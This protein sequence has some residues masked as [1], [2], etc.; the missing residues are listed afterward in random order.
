MIKD[1]ENLLVTGQIPE[2]KAKISSLSSIP[3][4]FTSL[5]MN[6]LH[7]AILHNRDCSLIDIIL[8]KKINV[9]AKNSHG[10]TALMLAVDLSRPEQMMALLTKKA[11]VNITNLKGQTA[12]HIALMKKELK[13]AKVLVEFGGDL[14]LPDLVEGK[15]PMHYASTCWIDRE[16]FK[17]F[18]Y[19]GGLTKIMDK[20]LKTPLDYLVIHEQ[21]AANSSFSESGY[22]DMNPLNT[23]MF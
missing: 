7:T 21:E 16:A 4:D 19:M 2:F 23:S 22:T 11:D 6:L 10:Q 5:Q 8:S 3:D 20:H 17:K 15:T 9:D 18:E 12:L 13:M 14:N 1:L